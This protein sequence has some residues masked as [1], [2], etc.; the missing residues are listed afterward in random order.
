MTKCLSD[1]DLFTSRQQRN[2]T[3]QIEQ[4]DRLRNGAAMIMVLCFSLSYTDAKQTRDVLGDGCLAASGARRH[5][6]DVR[7]LAYRARSA[8]GIHNCVR[9]NCHKNQ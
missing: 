6:H 8:C 3:F 1:S 9:T 5:I 4:K 7:S 2:A